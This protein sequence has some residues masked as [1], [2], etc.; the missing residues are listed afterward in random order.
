MVKIKIISDIHLELS[1]NP[2]IVINELFS[3]SL[4]TILI[5]AG[6][7]GNPY[8]DTY[9]N[10]LKHVSSC[11]YH[12]ILITGNHEYYNNEIH[13]TDNYIRQ[14]CKDLA[15]VHFLQ[16]DSIEIDNI[17][18][19]GCTLWSNCDIDYSS[20]IN[21]FVKIKKFSVYEYIKLHYLQAEFLK[22]NI[23]ENDKINIVV[24]HHLPSYKLIS[25]KFKNHFLNS[26]FASELENLMQYA[27]YWI[28]G[29]THQYIRK[30]I[31]NC[32]CII[33]PIGYNNEVTLYEK[34]C[35]IDI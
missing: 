2:N 31:G 17:R 16:T 13:E 10:L 33:N 6:D 35:M 29:H 23:I 11:Y 28:C 27:N 1:T 26:Y 14:L 21:D 12:I 8:S 25:Q 32:E 19:I 24:T 34:E 3:H 15:N 22:Q 20:F 18:F 9:L 7:I 5:L 4:N 30:K